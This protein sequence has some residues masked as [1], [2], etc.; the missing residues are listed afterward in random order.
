MKFLSVGYA[1]I[2]LCLVG[3]A[4]AVASCK[5]SDEAKP[6]PPA[7]IVTNVPVAVA[8]NAAAVSTNVAVVIAP[9][10][11]REHI[12]EQATVVGVVADV[13]V[14]PKGDVFLNFGGKFP[15]SVFSA[16]CFQNAIPT[17]Q[18]M[19]LKGRRISVSG[20]IKEYNGQV[21]IVLDSMDQISK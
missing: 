5:P 20:K 21:E 10:K 17:D 14:S 7:P 19:P 12:G 18:L 3:V 1:K 6:Q 9:T 15:N 13:H 16:V 4:L 2:S 11:A 8:T